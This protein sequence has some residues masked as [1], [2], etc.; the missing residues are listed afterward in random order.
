M[1][2][3]TALHK[4]SNFIKQLRHMKKWSE[5]RTRDQSGILLRYTREMA[6]QIKEILNLISGNDIIEMLKGKINKI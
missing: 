2:N 1:V 4:I 6:K 5:R 3:L